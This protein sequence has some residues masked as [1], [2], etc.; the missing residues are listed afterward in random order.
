[1]KTKIEQLAEKFN[2]FTAENLPETHKEYY[3]K[4]LKDNS[5]KLGRNNLPDFFKNYK[6]CE[7]GT[8]YECRKD[9]DYQKK[10][11]YYI[12]RVYN[13]FLAPDSNYLLMLMD[14]KGKYYFHPFYN[15]WHKY[16]GIGNTERNKV[17]NSLKEPNKIGVFTDKKLND[18]FLYCNELMRAMEKL[19]NSHNSKTNVI[20]SEVDTFCKRMR[21]AGA[22]ITGE[23][24]W[25]IDTDLFSVRL[26]IHKD[27]NYLEKNITFRGN[28]NQVAKLTEIYE[29]V[30]LND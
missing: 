2:L 5:Y 22:R 16:H 11:T 13:L 27:S 9:T 21:E 29:L 26:T 20:Q 15:Y 28:L 14:Y 4:M 17:I 23:N 19:Y 6:G 3:D 12:E 30:N 24:P 7:I 25:W 18:W 10:I 8:F 1:M